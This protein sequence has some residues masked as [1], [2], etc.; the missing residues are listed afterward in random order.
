MHLQV[1]LTLNRF[2]TAVRDMCRNE[3]GRMLLLPSVRNRQLSPLQVGKDS[4]KIKQRTEEKFKSI[5]PLLAEQS[6]HLV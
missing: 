3:L 4:S 1:L 5:H 2:F 6:I